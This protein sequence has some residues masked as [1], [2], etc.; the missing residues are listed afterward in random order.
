MF[1]NDG[2]NA[3]KP[4]ILPVPE[5]LPERPEP[6]VET[7][8]ERAAEEAAKRQKKRAPGKKKQRLSSQKKFALMTITVTLFMMALT[9]LM[10]KAELNTQYRNLTVT[11]NELGSLA[12]RV[13]QLSSEIEGSGSIVAI[14]E[15]AAE[16]GLRQADSSQIVYIS[17]D[18]ADHG[19]VLVEDKST[20]GL[21]LFF[22]K[23]AA[24]A[25]YLY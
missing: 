7:E 10:F 25:E 17:L 19:E 20:G 9:V 11:K 15:K 5:F 6:Q 4:E 16:L 1:E 12:S 22:N 3:L 2:S 8:L 23:V 18:N 14:E 13:E 21:N 24:I